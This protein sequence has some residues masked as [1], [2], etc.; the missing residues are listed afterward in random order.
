MAKTKT[1]SLGDLQ[2]AI[3][4]VLWKRGEATV[5][6]VHEALHG[7]RGLATTTI[8]TMLKKMESKGVVSHR[9]E[10]RRFIYQAT[11]TESA[12]TRSMISDLTERLFGGSKA[13]LVSHLISSHEVNADE[14]D[15]L[16]E[17][18]ARVRAEE[19]KQ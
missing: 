6:E 1:I 2:H 13:A 7:T 16:A 17:L 5:G 12:V 15:E 9:T 19:N 14:L 8:A 10:G 3:I 4:S 18:V 11:V